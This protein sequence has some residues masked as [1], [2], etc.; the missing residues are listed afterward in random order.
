MAIRFGVD[1]I[2]H[3]NPSWKNASIGLLTNDAAIDSNNIPTRTAL[4]NAG[5]N[6]VKL[7]APEHGIDTKGADGHKM[8]NGKDPLTGLSIISLYGNNFM[9]TAKDL[10][11]IEIL[12][13][14]IPDAG[15]RFYTY[16]WS[17]TYFMEAAA[18]HSLP[19]YIFDRPNPIGGNLSMAE[20]PFLD[21]NVSS[22]IGRFNIPIKHQCSYGEL[23]KYFNHQQ[24]WNADLK[25]IPC[26][27]WNRMAMFCDGN[28]EWKAPSPALK[29]F[30]A[31]LLYPGLCF[32]E[33]TNISI[34]RGGPYSFEWIG[35]SW[36]NRTLTQ[37]IANALMDDLQLIETENNGIHLIV[38]DPASYAAVFNGL[39]LL[40]I[41]KDL[42]PNEFK[43]MP[44]PT[45][46]NPTGENHLSLLLGIPKAET[47][48]ELPLKAWL[49]KIQI[50]IQVR[51][52]EKTIQPFLLY[53]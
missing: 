39:L 45:H 14:D 34:G 13:F 49:Q 10:E 46:A 47:L 48:F 12:L 26:N 30:E 32:F 24:C 28:M 5:F 51:T 16:L 53:P 50:L 15:T 37:Q 25:I 36:L 23:A 43:W 1:Q 8:E 18:K 6:I 2:I 17:M 38:K 22:F 40:K 31:T 44:Y 41:I 29:S 9:P 20:G 19:I 52:W 27:G 35:A 42:H 21:T 4:I 33:A 11:G 7:F 3:E